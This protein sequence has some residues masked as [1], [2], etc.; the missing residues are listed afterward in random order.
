MRF[1]KAEG[2]TATVVKKFRV[3]PED[4]AAIDNRAEKSGLSVSEYVRRCALGKRIDVRYDEDVILALRD[5]AINVGEL[6][7]S[8]M[9]LEVSFDVET[10]NQIAAQCVRTIRK[11]A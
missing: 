8:L 4:A 5:I 6:R 2:P 10:L 11:V 3:T 7:N 1:K 9:A